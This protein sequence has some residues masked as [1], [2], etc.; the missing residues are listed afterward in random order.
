MHNLGITKTT[1]E[2]G[3]LIIELGSLLQILSKFQA[4]PDDDHPDQ[5]GNT[6][7]RLEEEMADVHAS[8]IFMATKLNLNTIEIQN[9]I[10]MK[11]ER[12]NNWDNES[13]N[14]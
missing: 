13:N 11:I 7:K 5:E 4:Y 6:K 2:V 3:E 14:E 8:M 12:Y 10:I 1:E 9:R